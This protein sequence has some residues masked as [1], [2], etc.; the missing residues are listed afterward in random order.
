MSV[1]QSQMLYAS[2]IWASALIFEVNK[3]DMLKPQRMMAKRVACAYTTVPTNAILVMAGMLPLHI[4]VSER[5]AVSVA[6]KANST[7]QA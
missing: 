1:A 2:P 6:K 4:M 7:D 3:K 5:N